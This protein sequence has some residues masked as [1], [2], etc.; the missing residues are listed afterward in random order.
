LPAVAANLTITAD[1]TALEGASSTTG[2][3]NG[4]PI[5]AAHLR[6]LLTRAGALGL[7]TPEGGTLS[8]ALAGPDGQLL[9][10]ITP[11]ELARLARRGCPTHPD[12]GNSSAGDGTSQP[13]ACPALGTP[14]PTSAYTPTARQ[15][16]FV[17]T[18]D[19]RCRFPNCGQRVGWTDLDHVTAHAT[20]GAT[21]CTNLCCLCRSHHRLK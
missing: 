15:R 16:A 14:P 7:T 21:D 20:G 13:C 18:R 12:S 17:T 2:E 11:A 1:L 19:Q 3:I 6:E 10:T 9:A 4:L 8:Y 5:T